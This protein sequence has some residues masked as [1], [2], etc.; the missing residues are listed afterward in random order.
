[1]LFFAISVLAGILTIL[2]PCILPLLPIVIGSTEEGSKAKISKRSIVVITSLSLSV[3][4]FTLLLKASTLLIDIPQSFWRWF[5]GGIIILVG[6]A[7]LFPT[8]WSR[9]GLVQKISTAGNKA[10]GDGYQ[11]KSYTGDVLIGLALG[12]VFTTCSPTYLFII[13]TILPAGFGA[14]LFYLLGYTLGLALSLSLI[15]YFGQRIVTKLSG[16]SD[17]TGKVKKVF[18][19]II[20]I[21]GIAII[22][23]YDKK[24]E[25]WILDSGY[26][27]TIQFEESLLERFDPLSEDQSAPSEFNISANI[28]K[29][30]PETDWSLT[31]SRIENLVQGIPGG[32]PKDKIPALNEPSFEPISSFQHADSVQAIVLEDGD[33]I[34]VY[35]YNIL[36]WH[37]IVNDTVGE[38]PVAIT[39]CPLCGSAIVYDRSLRSLAPKF[40]VSGFLLES[41]MVMYD[42]ETETLWQQSTGEALAGE[43]FGET[44]R[45]YPFQLL[46]IGEIKS[47]YPKALVL[48]EDTGYRR[49]YARNPYS[50]Y[51]DT[52][53]FVFEPSVND[54]RYHPKTIMVVL[55]YGDTS[56]A[57]P[58]L[59]IIEGK[60]Y[61]V[62]IGEETVSLVKSDGEII[63]KD[64]TGEIVPFYFEM[65]FSYFAQ[66]GE[67]SVVFDPQ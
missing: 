15:A 45:L 21:V 3:I 39:F 36:T 57:I 23:G 46:T 52:D 67:E 14:G 61:G 7:I 33:Q 40:G 35:P 30:F 58:W 1:M 6:I 64:S 19:A 65:W 44:L 26:G 2:A 28:L 53:F 20:L 37:E 41:N 13:A 29:A 12:P 32:N 55:R 38:I 5:S 18:G 43:Y 42:S 51:E 24:L 54:D 50:G 27:A 10:I 17:A 66:H 31:D 49:D 62:V 8:V 11:K 63:A 16:G 59:E 56:L 48:S 47:K 4:A 22:T 60:E 34:K 25:T 9:I